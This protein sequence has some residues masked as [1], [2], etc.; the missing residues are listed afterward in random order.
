MLANNSSFLRNAL[1]VDSAA[2]CASGIAALLF[3]K[4]IA[5]FLGGTAPWFVLA[6][7]VVAIVYGIQIYLAARTKPINTGV[8][9]FAAYG[10]LAGSIV[11]AL[12][13]FANLVPFTIAGK[14]TIAIIADIGLIFAISQ[15]LGLRKLAK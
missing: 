5:S 3:S 2:S 8:A 14:W 9:K 13:V 12:L 4:A 15:L 7:G 10:N 11:V 1:L 6:F